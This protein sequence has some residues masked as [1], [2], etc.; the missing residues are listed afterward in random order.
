MF[1]GEIRQIDQ[2]V[3]ATIGGSKDSLENMGSID[4]RWKDDDGK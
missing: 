2:N 4:W 1:E 3:I